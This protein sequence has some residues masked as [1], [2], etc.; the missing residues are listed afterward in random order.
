MYLHDSTL[1]NGAEDNSYRFA[2]SNESVN[3]FVCFGTDDSVCPYD[4]LYRIIGVFNNQVKLIKWDFANSN[5]LGAVDNYN[6]KYG[7]DIR[8]VFSLIDSV[9][10]NGGIGA[11]SDPI[12]I[13]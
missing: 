5:L 3:N 10:Y 8:P 11:E 1:P 4:N 2:G 7:F 9:K 12:R 6:A 13:K